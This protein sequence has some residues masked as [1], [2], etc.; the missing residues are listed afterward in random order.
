ME[1]GALRDYG[2]TAIASLSAFIMLSVGA[3]LGY[4]TETFIG[5]LVVMGLL[6]VVFL[7]RNYR[8]GKSPGEH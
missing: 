7:F 2:T 6:C 8:R 4:G 5:Y 3:C 1:K